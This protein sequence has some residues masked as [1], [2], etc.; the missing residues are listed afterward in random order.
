M[1]QYKIHIMYRWSRFLF[2]I[3]YEKH[4]SL[5]IYLGPLIIG[6]GLTD[7]ASGFKAWKG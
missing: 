2:G 4:H 1:G 5:Q 3:D 7:H 6:I